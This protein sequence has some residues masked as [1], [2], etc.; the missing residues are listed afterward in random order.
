MKATRSPHA[1][2]TARGSTTPASA[3]AGGFPSLRTWHCVALL[4][5]LLVI[6][7][8]DILTQAAFFWEDFIY[9][10]YPTRVFAASSMAHGLMPFWNPFTFGGM[11]FLADI[12]NAVL[13][14]PYLLFP[15]FAV[16]RLSPVPVEYSTVLHYLLAGGGTFLLARSLGLERLSAT[17]SAAVFMLSGFMVAHAIHLTVISSVAWLP[18]ITWVLL[19]LM[20]SRRWIFVPLTGVGLALSIYAGFP[21]VFYYVFLFAGTVFLFELVRLSRRDPSPGRTAIQLSVRF[22]VAVALALGLAAVQLLPTMELAPQTY[23]A[24]ITYQKSLEGSLSWSQLITALVPKFF[25]VSDASGYRYWGPGPYWHY[26]ETCFYIGIPS[27]LLALAGLSALRS[28]P[29]FAFLAVASA[30]TLLVALGDSFVLHRI[31]FSVLPG[32]SKFRDPARILMLYSMAMAL[33]AG[34]GSHTLLQGNPAERR[35]A[36]Y[37]GAIAAAAVLVVLLAV[38][39]STATT[40]AAGAREAQ[41]MS[42]FTGSEVTTAMIVTVVAGLLLYLAAKPTLLPRYAVAGLFILWFIDIHQFG[43]GQNNGHLNPTDY[44]DRPGTLVRQLQQEQT[45]ELFRVNARS[46]GYMILD[47]NQ[48]M[49]DR[50]YLLEGYTPLAL[51]NTR[52]PARSEDQQLD[53]LNVKYKIHVDEQRQLM[54]L[55]RRMYFMPRAYWV[56]GAR[57]VPG[58]EAAGQALVD[59]TFDFRRTAVVETSDSLPLPV[60]SAE[61]AVPF[62]FTAYSQNSMEGTIDAPAAGVV[63]FSEVYY[64][65]WTATVDGGTRPILRTNQCQRGVTVEAGHHTI[66]LQFFPAS[67]LRGGVLSL[68]SLVIAVAITLGSR[69][70]P[71]KLPT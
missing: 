39:P 47:R 65:G 12:Q 54:D 9:Y 60:R 3:P 24:A 33:L 57:P 66:A 52:P 21:Q 48:G 31:L 26:W 14:P 5:I 42:A 7:F 8:R 22:G 20:E 19:Q 58:T 32:Y 51:T 50:V 6:F 53:M 71:Q 68:A 36:A 67:F 55:Q 49:V 29:M 30:F 44:F 17:L 27:L 56:G 13:Y 16:G 43:F 2:G 1:R 63:V 18:L 64:P 59:S 23:R 69:R 45:Q 25:G 4:G 28:R 10:Y 37:G 38:K 62:H 61:D 46:G 11:P 15:L 40:V 35:R 70:K 41:M 34:L